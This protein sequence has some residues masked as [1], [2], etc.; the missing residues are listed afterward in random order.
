MIGNFL[1]INYIFRIKFDIQI[2]KAEKSFRSKC[3][4]AQ[5]VNFAEKIIKI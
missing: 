4:N 3:S 2:F 1:M 5:T